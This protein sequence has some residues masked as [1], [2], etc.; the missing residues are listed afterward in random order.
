M[1]TLQMYGFGFGL[2]DWLHITYVAFIIVK[3]QMHIVWDNRKVEFGW[4]HFILYYNDKLFVHLH[5]CAFVHLCK[6]K[7]QYI[8][9]K[10]L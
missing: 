4:V 7:K 9:I 5:S 2:G 10:E 1:H 3:K 6:C 8:K